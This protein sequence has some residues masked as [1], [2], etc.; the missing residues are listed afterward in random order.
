MLL[1]GFFAVIA[2]SLAQTPAPAPKK[3]PPKA[4]QAA[5]GMTNQK[6]IEMVAAGLADDAII[7]AIGQA[8]KRDFDLTPDGLIALAK[9]KVSSA[10]IRVMQGDDASAQTPTA[11]RAVSSAS[12]TPTEVL[13]Q[14]GQS[15]KVRL[16]DGLTSET[17]QVGDPVDF[18]VV[19]DLSVD[20]HVVIKK[21]SKAVG[22]VTDVVAQRLT[23]SG[24]LTFSIDSAKTVTG[25][26]VRLT[27]SQS[28]EGGKRLGKGLEV[29]FAPRSEYTA[30]IDDNVAVNLQAVTQGQVTT[31][32]TVPP[33]NAARTAAPFNPTSTQSVEGREA[34]IYFKDGD[35]LIQL[36]P[37]VF[38]GGKSSGAL[39]SSF[40]YGIKKAKWKAVVR[41]AHAGQ[42]IQV[43]SPEF[44]FFFE[45]TGAGLSNAFLG[46]SSPNE[47]VLAKMES[48]SKERELTVGEFGA[49][50]GS[51]T[52]TSSDD[53]VEISVEKLGPGSYK[54]TPKTSLKR[55]EYCFFY[56]AGASQFALAGSGKLFDFGVD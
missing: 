27:G 20:G 38:S 10:V 52:G 33:A 13:L 42:R 5:A 21:G 24:K 3:T 43:S 1:L 41:S 30:T 53:T 26:E 4:Q 8:P 12:P 25:G 40:T 44:Y 29:T 55:G 9:G 46:A 19:D 35:K 16:T 22:K 28:A 32:A 11:Q 45:K 50:G 15:V 49:W 37:A 14:K 2:P 39:A 51:T 31:G 23:R 36:E 6:V 54:V 18:E 17:A 7:K 56:A 48:G 34:G 47:F